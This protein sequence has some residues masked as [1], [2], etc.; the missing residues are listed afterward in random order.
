MKTAIVKSIFLF[1][2]FSN[3]IFAKDFDDLFNITIEIQDETID[4]SIDN[5][6]ND[7]LFRL[8]GYQDLEKA[9]VIKGNF[10]S[11]DFLK[12]YSVISIKESKFLQASFDEEIVI[13]QFIENDISFIGRNRPVIFLDIQIDNGFTKPFKIESIPYET[14]LESSIQ[15]I[16][17]NISEQRG[18]F[19]E[20]PQNTINL[21]KKEY[22]FESEKD[23]EFDQYKFDYFESL[24]I[25][26]S[27]INNWSMSYKNQV[28]FFD[29]TDDIIERIKFLFNNLSSDYL[30]NFI[31]DNSERTIKMRVAEVSSSE[32]LDNL[33]DA[34]NKMISIKEYT[35]TTF[36]QNEI[37]F[38]LTIFGTEDQFI[39]SVKTHKDFLF[40]AS[41]TSLIEASLISS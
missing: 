32:Q 2:I 27:G 13:N 3:Q 14:E 29:N 22:F 10:N 5:S 39:K 7:L 24:L 33:L 17:Y 23:D 4:K 25:S 35:I 9:K 20:F 26:R 28:S 40:K 18:L 6:F 16:F 34:L 38:T 8:L 12:R 31:L 19:F 41:S 37:S 30:G 11:K 1:I 21:D 36:K 15:K